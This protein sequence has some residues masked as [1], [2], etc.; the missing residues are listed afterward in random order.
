MS[1]PPSDGN[2]SLPP[3]RPDPI[4]HLKWLLPLAVVLTAALGVSL[5]RAIEYSANPARSSKLPMVSTVGFFMPSRTTPVP[6]S[7]PV[8]QASGSTRQVTMSS[9]VGKPLV[10]NMW[11]SSCTVCMSETPAMEAV[12]RKVGG[13]VEFVGIDTLDEKGA[14]LAFLRRY[15]VTYRQLFDPEEKVGSGYKIPGLPV[16]VFVSPGGKVV[17]E[18]LGALDEKSLAHYLRMLFGVRV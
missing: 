18:N 16:T 8:L 14:A 10:I 11:S 12:A 3:A 13:R 2:L 4:R 6:F 7:L 15:H 1:E 9:L 17:G 5:V